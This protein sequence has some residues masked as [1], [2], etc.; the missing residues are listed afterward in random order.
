MRFRPAGI[1][2]LE[3]VAERW[4]L[5]LIGHHGNTINI[6]GQQSRRTDPG[7]TV[8]AHGHRERPHPNPHRL[9]F[10]QDG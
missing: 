6:D 4:Q 3:F 5:S 9:V 10:P 1:S 7:A 8:A 2:R